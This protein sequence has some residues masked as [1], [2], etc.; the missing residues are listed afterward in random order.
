MSYCAHTNNNA[1]I[2][3]PTLAKSRVGGLRG[4]RKRPFDDW[5]LLTT[6]IEGSLVLFVRTRK[7]AETINEE[8]PSVY[9]RR[10]NTSSADDNTEPTHHV[11]HCPHHR[12]ACSRREAVVRKFYIGD[13]L[14]DGLRDNK[15]TRP[16]HT[17]DTIHTSSILPC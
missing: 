9:Y 6:E 11:A 2:R 8:R 10:P 4:R 5:V 3:F 12:P 15:Q 13:F 14:P 17:L 7:K 16:R 1:F